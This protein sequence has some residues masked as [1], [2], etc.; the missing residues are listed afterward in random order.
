MIKLG[1]WVVAFSSAPFLLYIIFWS[2]A[3]R[4]LALDLLA[5][6]GDAIGLSMLV[7][8]VIL[9]RIRQRAL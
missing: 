4:P 8:G 2:D 1:F 3:D 9:L 5:V 7:F 6:F